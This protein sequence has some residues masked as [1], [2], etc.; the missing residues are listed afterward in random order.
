MSDNEQNDRNVDESIKL[1]K[2]LKVTEL[3]SELETRGLDTDGL[4]P[5]LA[6]RLQEH[7]HEQGHDVEI[8]NFNSPEDH[9]SIE[10]K[11]E[12]DEDGSEEEEA[13]D[14]D[15]EF[16]LSPDLMEESQETH[17]KS[18]EESQEKSKE[19]ALED[20]PFLRSGRTGIEPENEEDEDVSEAEE[21]MDG[22]DEFS[23]SPD[24][25][26]ESKEIHEKSLEESHEKSKEGALEDIPFLRSGRTGIEPKNEEEEDVSEA[27]D[28]MD[29]DD[30][31]SLSPDDWRSKFTFH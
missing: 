7:L 12:E 16:S 31:F 23:L 1:L 3:K 15:D 29:G 21:A 28:A 5:I 13:M 2:D 24:L 4:K 18:L 19:G 10:P 8:F 11:N 14:G 17:E 26:E 27:E 30:E 25:M 22:D 6:D 20:I 9:Q